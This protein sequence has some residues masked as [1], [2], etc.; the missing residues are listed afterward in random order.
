MAVY[1][2]KCLTSR[3]ISHFHYN[4]NTTS[5]DAMPGIS[6]HASNATHGTSRATSAVWM[7][8]LLRAGYRPLVYGHVEEPPAHAGR[9]AGSQD[10]VSFHCRQQ[11]TNVWHDR[12][13]GMT[14][15]K[16]VGWVGG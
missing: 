10:P 7:P 15:G 14:P 16:H 6:R 9:A 8:D 13:F 2:V 11:R 1:K 5:N 12:R 3:H 4:G